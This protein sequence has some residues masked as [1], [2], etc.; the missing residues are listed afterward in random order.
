MAID[1]D[2]RR[3]PP[4]EQSVQ[5]EIESAVRVALREEG[6]DFSVIDEVG[7]TLQTS[8]V[9]PDAG[10]VAPRSLIQAALDLPSLPDWSLTASERVMNRVEEILT[11]DE[12]SSDQG[13]EACVEAM[14]AIEEI[15]DPSSQ[16]LDELVEVLEQRPPVFDVVDVDEENNH[17]RAEQVTNNITERRLDRVRELGFRAGSYRSIEVPNDVV[18]EW[19]FKPIF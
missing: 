1:L 17:V 11:G 3:I 8:M 15:C 9:N 14:A 13:D 12:S 4:F 19:L 2:R 6:V 7:R 5:S 10:R 16:G 18:A